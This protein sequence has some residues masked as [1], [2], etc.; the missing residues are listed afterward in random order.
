VGGAALA[1]GSVTHQITAG[2]L[3]VAVAISVVAGAASFVSPC[4]LPLVPG[5]LSYITGMSAADAGHRAEPV[6]ERAPALV[7]APVAAA[8]VGTAH[9]PEHRPA[10]GH[11]AGAGRVGS[12]RD[13]ADW[14]GGRVLVGG[15]LFILGFTL[16]FVTLGAAF[17]GLG[18]LL[19]AHEV[20]VTRVFG[21]ITIVLGLSFAGAFR[22]LRIANAEVRLHRVPA[23]GMAGAPV[24]GV[25]FGL[26]WTPCIGPTLS[27]VLGLAASSGASA[28]RGALLACAYCLG[29]GVPFILV[30]LAFRRVM[31]ALAAVKRHY[32]GVMAVGGGFLVVIGILELTGLW[33]QLIT[34][35]QTTLPPTP[36]LL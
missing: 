36:A 28:D 9:P 24:L 10:A 3:L 29:L 31:A 4:V 20:T 14:P 2:P 17:G 32:R 6:V 30:G 23:L 16:V 1:A 21:A 27:A 25:L 19:R 8:S 26:G 18:G 12:R 34:L 5:Y 22:R 7:A 11:R 15:V 35:V 13:V 33:A